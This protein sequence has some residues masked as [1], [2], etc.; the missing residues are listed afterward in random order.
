MTLY[1]FQKDQFLENWIFKIF[2]F[3]GNSISAS[4]NKDKLFNNLV[5]ICTYIFKL[6]LKFPSS[7]QSFKSNNV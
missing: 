6:N 1:D 4:T 7:N 2:N 5:L 3:G